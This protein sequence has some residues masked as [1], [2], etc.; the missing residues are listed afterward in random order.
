MLRYQIERMTPWED[1]IYWI[2]FDMGEGPHKG[3]VIAR[4]DTAEW[5]QLVG[6]ALNHFT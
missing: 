5:A 1:D 3:A 4:C 2:V 6:R